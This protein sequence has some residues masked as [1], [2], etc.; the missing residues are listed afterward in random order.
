[1]DKC[2][3]SVKHDRPRP[4]DL[5]PRLPWGYEPCPHTVTHLYRLDVDVASGQSKLI[6]ACEEH[7]K[8]FDIPQ[9]KGRVI[10][11]QDG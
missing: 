9:Y 10:K 4:P 2:Y 6:A 5:N 11:I 3:S 1:M 8:N 7:I